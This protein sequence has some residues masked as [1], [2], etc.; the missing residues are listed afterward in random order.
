[1]HT[2]IAET[3]VSI[4]RNV[5]LEKCSFNMGLFGN[6]GS[7]KSFIINKINESLDID[8]YAFFYI[9]VWKFIGNPLHRSVLFEINKQLKTNLRGLFP[10][11]YKENN[12]TLESILYYEEQLQ[13]QIPISFQE[14]DVKIKN[15]FHC[16]KPFVISFIGVVLSLSIISIIVP[17]LWL[18]SL[19]YW[20]DI[21][22]GLLMF[23]SNLIGALIGVVCILVYPLKKLGEL[24]Y[25]GLE[26]QNYKTLPNFSPEH[27]E[28]IFLN[29]VKKITQSRR[30][31]IIVFDNLDRC[32]PKYAYETLSTIKTFMDVENCFYIVPC[33]DIAVKQYIVNNYSITQSGEVTFAETLGVEFF[34]KLFDTYI[35]IPILQEIDRDKFIEE[36]LKELLVYEELIKYLHVIKQIL[37]FGYKGLTPR[38]IKKF[39]NDFSSYYLLA[40]NIDPNK[41]TLLK[42][43]PFF[44]IM[45]VIKQKWN[46]MENEFIK[47]AQ[48][49]GHNLKDK[50]FGEEYQ[51]FITKIL[52]FLPQKLPSLLPFIYFKETINEQQLKEK[53]LNG[54]YI[55]EFNESVYKQLKIE[56]K[57][58]IDN[59]NI[60]YTIQ[61]INSCIN[62]YVYNQT[63]DKN[64][65]SDFVR[66]IG[67]LFRRLESLENFIN[68]L[69]QNKEHLELFYSFLSE[70][71]VQDLKIIKQYIINFLQMQQENYNDMQVSLFELVISD[72]NKLF[73]V[74]EIQSIFQ[75]IKNV[76]DI[77]VNFQN[78]VKVCLDEKLMGL[79]P[80]AFIN[81]IINSISVTS[82]TAQTKNCIDSLIPDLLSKDTKKILAQRTQELL[83]HVNN[84]LQY[85]YQDVVQTITNILSCLKLFNKEDIPETIFVNFMNI[86][87]SVLERLRIANDVIK[88][89]L[90]YDLLF[91]MFNFVD[92][93]IKFSTKLKQFMEF[94]RE[95]FINKIKTTDFSY[96]ET[97]LKLEKTKQVLLSDNSIAK[98]LYETFANMIPSHCMLMFANDCNVKNLECLLNVI[99][100]NFIKINKT[101]CRDNII[102]KCIEIGDA[103]L[104]AQ[105]FQLLDNYGYKLTMCNCRESRKLF[106][107]LYLTSPE[108]GFEVLATI[109]KILQPQEFSRTVLLPIFNYIYNEFR[110]GNSI[111]NYLNVLTILNNN[112]IN[113]NKLFIFDF[114]NDMLNSTDRGNIDYEFLIG[115]AQQL[116]HNGYDIKLIKKKLR[117]QKENLNEKLMVLVEK[118]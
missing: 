101:K 64:L 5:N 7:G 87:Y 70:I 20:G 84:R 63:L 90:A 31:I 4:I 49:L 112:F 79:V 97:I 107:N 14:Q 99:K 55:Q 39:I 82:F 25:Y 83:I 108:R 88:R 71:Y 33:D 15:W 44:A 115:L 110:Q 109:K 24:I 92:D 74:L 27:F 65:R 67:K 76:N 100:E 106:I 45:M 13:N 53:L 73:T 28:R 9:D 91:E 34:D 69:T 22:K 111:I 56:L 116:K 75:N 114:I 38:Q 18:D 68:I 43:I 11:G 42:D 89:Q 46:Y 95:L 26:I 12:R 98:I 93:D 96:F 36:Q 29:I 30:K 6:W 57:N 113:D 104:I 16:F 54:D 59:N 23:N 86:L 105:V 94:N 10:D 50:S 32:E 40:K 117:G 72:K 66:E 52:P 2:K 118:L 80:Q 51:T 77:S 78:Y 37:Y 102:K 47:N 41:K 61:A 35:R 62:T 103:Y 1:V 60:S 8:N 21:I 17:E 3:I 85:N 19:K 48:L 58:V 81:L